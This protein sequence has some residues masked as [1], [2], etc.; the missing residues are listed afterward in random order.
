MM[1]FCKETLMQIQWMTP[2]DRDEVVKRIGLAVRRRETVQRDRVRVVLQAGDGDESGR[3]LF[4]DQIAWRVGRW[5]QFVHQWVGRYRS[6]GL[7]ALVAKKQ[8]GRKPKLTP[9]QDEQL[10]ARLDAGPRPDDKVCA[11]RGRDIRR[12]VEVARASSRS[13]R[14]PLV[15]DTVVDFMFDGFLKG[16][17]SAFAGELFDK[18]K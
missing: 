9:Q 4:R 5:R 12:I 17:T 13:R 15:S 10:N 18:G 3:E 6:S 11:L 16:A 2:G 7:D 8:P 1:P 14:L